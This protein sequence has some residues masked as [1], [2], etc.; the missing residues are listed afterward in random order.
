MLMKAGGERCAC[1]GTR[2]TR[3]GWHALVA[4]LV[5][6]AAAC[7]EGGGPTITE[8]DPPMPGSIVLT[9]ETSGFM[10]DDSYELLVDGVSQG[11]IGANDQMTVEG[12]DPATYDVALGDV[13]TNCAVDGASVDVAAEAEVA[14]SLTVTCSYDEPA[15]Y[16]MRF[17]RERPDMDD[18][19]AV[20]ECPF[21]I[22]STQEAWDFYVYYNGGTDPHSVIRQNQTT[23]VEIAHLPGVTLEALTEA[24]VG[25]A[26]FTTDLVADPFDAG[27]VILI[28]TDM[29]YVYALGNPV[30]DTDAQT[31]TFDAALVVVPAA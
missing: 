22:C 10:K 31:L 6:G 12:L 21:S 4:L 1:V 11:T 26:T 2:Q 29:G 9:T 28:R 20:T 14:V 16:T 18:G 24:D 17:G 25:G 19:G 30:E 23:G 27:R 8:P 3:R 7:E 5:I 15:S 13:A